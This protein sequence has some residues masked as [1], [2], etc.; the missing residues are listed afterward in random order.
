[1]TSQ[2]TTSIAPRPRAPTALPTRR[3][4]P[5]CSRRSS[6]RPSRTAP[7]T[8]RSR[9][10]ASPRT[11]RSST[12]P[13]RGLAKGPAP[14]AR[15]R[16]LQPAAPLLG[17]ARRCSRWPRSVCVRLGFLI[18]ALA[19]AFHVALDRAVGYGLRTRDGFQRRNGLSPRAREIVDVALELLEEEGPDGLSMRRLADRLGIQA[20][21][22]YKHLPD[23]QALEAAII[24][25][26][27]E[28][29]AEAFEA[30]ARRAAKTRSPRSPSPT[31]GSPGASTPLPADDGTRAPPRP[32]RARRR[33]PCRPALSTRPSVATPTSPAPHGHSR[34]A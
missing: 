2:T 7:A 29:Q 25:A 1:M 10:S 5:C 21:S 34:M 31:A 32:A 6:S 22:I 16:R 12:A 4:P 3:W 19:W 26:G 11:W 23:K 24:S 27:F 9:C 13:A 14:P 17:A 8:G 33:S 28:L 18:G 30:G 20:P 15:S